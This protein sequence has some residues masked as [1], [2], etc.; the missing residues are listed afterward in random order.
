M[1]GWTSTERGGVMTVSGG[2]LFWPSQID[3]WLYY[4]TDDGN[5]YPD[6][7]LAVTGD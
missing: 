2:Q 6:L 1:V 3:E 4:D 7:K 5:W